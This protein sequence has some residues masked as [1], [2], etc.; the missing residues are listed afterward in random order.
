MAQTFEQ[1]SDELVE[2]LNDNKVSENFEKVLSE[3][4]SYY[5]YLSVDN[6]IEQNMEISLKGY[7][8]LLENSTQ[9]L[10]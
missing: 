5:G 3:I 9:D 4:K 7:Q 6:N 2:Y 8:E 10:V 1:R